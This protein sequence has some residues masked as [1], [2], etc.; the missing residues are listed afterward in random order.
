[1]KL[2]LLHK[3][4]QGATALSGHLSFMPLC[5]IRYIQKAPQSSP[6][7]SDSCHAFVSNLTS[8]VRRSS[9]TGSLIVDQG[10][11]QSHILEKEMNTLI[12]GEG[13]VIQDGIY[14]LID[15]QTYMA[16]HLPF[17]Q[18]VSECFHASVVDLTSVGP[19]LLSWL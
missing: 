18:P 3:G 15:R 4:W 6:H 10:L 8:L 13:L 16:H 19:S 9:I 12:Q 11:L 2:I 7:H 14:P 1:M 5:Q 17:R